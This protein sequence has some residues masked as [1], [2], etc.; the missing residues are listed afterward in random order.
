M[1]CSNLPVKTASRVS[2]MYD[3]LG[4]ISPVIIQGKM[5]FQQF[6][7]LNI[8]W[9]ESVP[10]DLAFRWS[11]WLISLE[12][13]S[14]LRFP[15]C[16]IPDELV[17]GSVELHHFCDASEVVT[18]HARLSELS[19]V[20]VRSMFL[21]SL[22][23]IDWHQSNKLE[24][25]AAVVASNLDCVVRRELDIELMKSTFWTD[26]MIS[27]AYIQSDSRRFKQLWQIE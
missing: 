6:T 26:S 12:H 16:V 5:L 21:C 23:R 7:R 10:S 17:D 27:L 24:L 15:R 3:P 22:A 9:D 11:I 8:P 14:S 1:T 4:L 25:L 20:E 19:N 2:S 18:E 13:I